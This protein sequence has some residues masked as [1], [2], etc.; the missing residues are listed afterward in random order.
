MD[1][2]AAFK[3]KLL[4][5]AVVIALAI[6]G[7]LWW[8]RAHPDKKNAGASANTLAGTTATASGSKLSFPEFNFSYTLPNNNWMTT[9]ADLGVNTVATVL[10]INPSVM[11]MIMAS[12]AITNGAGEDALAELDKTGFSSRATGLKPVNPAPHQVGSIAGVRYELAPTVEGAN[13]A[14]VLWYC[15]TNGFRYALAA[16]GQATQKEAVRAQG[17]L[18]FQGF[19]LLATSRS[20]TALGS[21][22]TTEASSWRDYHSRHGYRVEVKASHWSR[23]DGLEKNYP[24]VEFGLVSQE[25]GGLLAFAAGLVD[26]QPAADALASA[27]LAVAGVPRENIR[28]IAGNEIK[29]G[30][31]PGSSMSFERT[32]ERTNLL[33][34][35][36]LLRGSN[37]FYYAIAWV[38]KSHATPD[39]FLAQALDMVAV[40]DAAPANPV[41]EDPRER[42][43]RR[44]L[45]NGL[46]LHY[47][48]ARQHTPARGYFRLA[49]DAKPDRACLLQYFDASVAA[50]QYEDTLKYLE[51]QAA[52][53]GEDAGFQ[54][55]RAFLQARCGQAEAAFKNYTAAFEAGFKDETML[56]DYLRL[57]ARTDRADAAAAKLAQYLKEKDT[58]ELRLVQSALLRQQKQFPEAIGVLKEQEKRYS[59]N[60]ALSR[61]LVDCYYDAGRHKDA[62]E[63]CARLLAKGQDT[64]E[65]HVAKARNELAL[66]AYRQAKVSLEI[67]LEKDPGNAAAREYMRQIPGAEK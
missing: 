63:E 23:F 12:E 34:R 32:T 4:I 31:W 6:G 18:A 29:E 43:L 25:K 13:R 2:E 22:R 67:A 56:M 35:H 33:Y 21:S 66:K 47:Q 59:F 14:G 9:E 44:E 17:E 1:E 28:V 61:E 16:M 24:G 65:T 7:Q 19:T 62:I 57:L 40:P 5:A 50:G 20:V 51:E 64:A 49:L 54:A 36:K 60:P 46:G 58:L 30:P 48:Q 39:A 38:D 27:C 45:M 11:V 3:R 52:W 53:L 41:A 15:A 8:N 55:R 37:E 42:L 26:K 10:R